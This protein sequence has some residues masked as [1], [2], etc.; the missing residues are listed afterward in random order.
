MAVRDSLR[1]LAIDI[2][3][4]GLGWIAEATRGA[5]LES[6]CS[7]RAESLEKKLGSCQVDSVSLAKCSSDL[8]WAREK[9]QLEIEWTKQVCGTGYSALFFAFSLGGVFGVLVA[10]VCLFL[11]THFSGR[12]CVG[13]PVEIVVDSTLVGS[14]VKKISSD[15]S[16]DDSS[17]EKLADARR[18]ARALCGGPG[19]FTLEGNSDL[20]Q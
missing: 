8:E 20:H 16:G 10:T 5:G 11:S 14:A 12:Q 15:D 19:S 6:S 13:Q 9:S 7:S 4:V 1:H 18:R 17:E 3:R 2:A